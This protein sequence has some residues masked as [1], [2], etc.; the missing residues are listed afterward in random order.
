[1]NDILSCSIVGICMR[2]FPRNFHRRHRDK[3]TM[4]FTIWR[5]VDFIVSHQYLNI[6]NIFNYFETRWIL[7][8]G[9]VL[10]ALDLHL[11]HLT[12]TIFTDVEC[13]LQVHSVYTNEANLHRKMITHRISFYIQTSLE[14]N[15]RTM[16][17]Y[18]FINEHRNQM[19]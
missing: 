15:F 19:K 16:L 8:R 11:N 14:N 13:Y 4:L 1:M 7:F 3:G 10:D 2:C 17:Q 9:F 12:T 5:E 6:F 18:L